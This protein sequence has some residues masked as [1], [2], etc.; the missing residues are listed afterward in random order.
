MLFGAFSIADA[1]YAPVCMR[2]I[3]YALPVPE[4]ISAYVQRVCALPGVKALSTAPA[5]NRISVTLKSRT[6]CTADRDAGCLPTHAD[7]H[8]R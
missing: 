5:P 3:T 4:D 7:T 1:Y 2:L 8:A 6:V